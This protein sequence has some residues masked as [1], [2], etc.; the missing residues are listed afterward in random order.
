MSFAHG[1]NTLDVTAE[2]T[3]RGK[4]QTIDQVSQKKIQP[5]RSFRRYRFA[6][7]PH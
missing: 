3:Y 1:W 5:F 4:V 6:H 2:L 7:R